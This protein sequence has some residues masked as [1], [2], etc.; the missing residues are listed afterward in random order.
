MELMS[1]WFGVGGVVI[2]IISLVYAIYANREAARI[3]N[4]TRSGAWNLYQSANTA[5]GQIQTSLNLYKEKHSSEIDVDVIESLAKS[6]QLCLT[7]YHDSIRFIQLMEPSFSLKTIEFWID[8]GKIKEAHA[9][10]FRKI[11][12]GGEPCEKTQTNKAFKSDS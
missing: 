11:V 3:K 8:T 1:F 6:D 7:V 4:V 2:G 12:V 10:N 5:G 9:D